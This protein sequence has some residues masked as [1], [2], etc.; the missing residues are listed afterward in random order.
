[1]F[2]TVKG[3]NKR[4][5]FNC[6]GNVTGEDPVSLKGKCTSEHKLRLIRRKFILELVHSRL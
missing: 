6:R 2:A 4:S 3:T 5:G 1:M